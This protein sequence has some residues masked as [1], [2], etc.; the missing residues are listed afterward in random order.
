MSNTE[1]PM[2]KWLM[3]FGFEAK[4]NEILNS[5]TNHHQ[6]QRLTWTLDIPCWILG[7]KFFYFKIAYGI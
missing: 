1:C 7:I 3:R 4:K 2:S 6:E 5:N